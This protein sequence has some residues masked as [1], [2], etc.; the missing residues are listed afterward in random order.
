MKP[1][2]PRHA[3]GFTLTEI[4]VVM[5]IVALLLGGMLMPLSAQQDSRYRADTDAALNDI[6]EALLGFAAVNGRLPC[7]AQ[8]NLANDGVNAAGVEATTGAGANLAC[9]CTS[10]T[11]DIAQAGGSTCPTADGSTVWGVLPWTTLGLPEQDPWGNRYTYRVTNMFAR[12]AGQTTFGA[13][14]TPSSNPTQAGFALCTQ[15]GITI[16][17]A[18]S[19]TTLASNVPV[20]VIAHG[21]TGGGGYGTTG[22]QAP[23]SGTA[24]EQENYN[25]DATFVSNTTMDDQLRWIPLGL[26]M[27]RMLSA[28]KL[29]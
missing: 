27:N 29:P 23:L 20:I 18:A 2:L 24:D 3:Q 4:A 7:P 25:A 16:L 22:T 12:G 26:L 5:V 19:S 10:V 14:C 1:S 6:R 21:K 13:T 15:G 8:A 17:T 11:S 9:A 28:S